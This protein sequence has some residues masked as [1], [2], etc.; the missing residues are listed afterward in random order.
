M[1]N[2]VIGLLIIVLGAAAYYYFGVYQPQSEEPP[3]PPPIVEQELPAPEPEPEPEPPPP[4]VQEPAPMEPEPEVEPLPPLAESDPLVHDSLTVLLGEAPVTQFLVGEDLVSRFVA[5]IDALTSRQIPGSIMAVQELGGEFEAT[6]D[7]QPENVIRNAEG[8]PIPQYI[9]D[10]V[11]YQRYTSQVET[12]EAVDSSELLAS[13]QVLA[14]LF[15]QAWVELGYPEGEFDERLVEVID[16]LLAAP[17]VQG[18]VRLVK[19]EA[20]YLFADPDLESLPAGQ[21]ILLRMGSANANRVKA[22]LLEIRN[23]LAGM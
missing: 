6:T 14:P 19:P 5:S 4:P 15:E 22:K 18:P 7:E 9:L 11:N 17:E 12:F 16:S 21:K 13:Y 2:A 8:D 3:P 20:V 1:K 23:L 10:P